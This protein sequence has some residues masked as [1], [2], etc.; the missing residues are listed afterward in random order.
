MI[1][2]ALPSGAAQRERLLHPIAPTLLSQYAKEA[3]PSINTISD[4]IMNLVTLTKL[5][6]DMHTQP[7]SRPVLKRIRFKRYF[8]FLDFIQWTENTELGC[9]VCTY[10]YKICVEEGGVMGCTYV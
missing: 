9:S 6:T 10:M 7:I 2:E 1:T 3:F 4:P 5:C 8:F